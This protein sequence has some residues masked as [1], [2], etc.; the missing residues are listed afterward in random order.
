MSKMEMGG[1]PATSGSRA[2]KGPE[3]GFIE[4]E[5]KFFFGPDTA[6]KLVALG[7]T[8]EGNITFRDQYYDV[9][10]FRLTL[11]DHW[12]RQR[13]GTGWEL[14]CPP[15]PQ[16]GARVPGS[17]TGSATK[18]EKPRCVPQAPAGDHDD[19]RQ[20]LPPLQPLERAGRRESATKYLEVTCPR[21][22]V[23]RVC[24]LMGVDPEP[25]WWENVAVA[26][27]EL[28]LQEFASFV[29]RRRQ[30]RLDNLNVVLDEADFGYAVG[31]VEAIVRKWEEV[32]E[33]LE[34]IQKLGYQLGEEAIS[35][36]P[37][38]KSIDMRTRFPGKM[39][40]Y[41]YKFRPAHYNLLM[42]AGRLRSAGDETDGQGGKDSA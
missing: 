35:F 11:A 42:Q 36:G 2:G 4:V 24:E 28:S 34:N 23:A 22:I 15:Q 32:S 38:L 12:L 39:S 9:P 5:Q 30:Y 27:K 41:L 14:K 17:A 16:E 20:P 31:E 1:A 8:L 10:D 33:A 6:E 40:A 37:F 21:E 29:T 7:A 3:S 13:E 25:S 18:N 19:L 26:T